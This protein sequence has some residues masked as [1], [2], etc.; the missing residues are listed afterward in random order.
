MKSKKK[1]SIVLFL[2]WVAGA[3][4]FLFFHMRNANQI[5]PEEA[6][7][8]MEYQKTDFSDN[9]QKNCGN[10][11]LIDAVVE[12]GADFDVENC[13]MQ[14]ASC[15]QIDSEMVKELF[16]DVMDSTDVTSYNQIDLFGNEKKGFV[17]GTDHETLMLAEN[18][19]NYGKYPE[20]NYINSAF[21]NP[22]TRYEIGNTELYSQT[23]ELLFGDKSEV[24]ECVKTYLEKM[25]IN[26]EDAVW[27]CYSLDYLTMQ[28]QAQKQTDLKKDEINEGWDEADEVYDFFISEQTEGL[29][30]YLYDDLMKGDWKV[31]GQAP[32]SLIYGKDGIIGIKISGW[33]CGMKNQQK[34][35][36]FVSLDEIANTITTHFADVTNVQKITITKMK[37]YMYP[38]L[39]NENTCKVIPIWEC[40]FENENLESGTI[41]I[42]AQTGEEFF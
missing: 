21:H 5:K 14:E 19:L 4:L 1:L 25:G 41:R 17:Y 11:V 32:V 28:E 18:Y 26:R 36:K 29:P 8:I 23:K 10:K 34:P 16:S 31:E 27:T 24:T 7:D 40:E 37:L 20:I 30:V 39:E 9:Y 6:V 33:I 3:I 38:V 35:L 42:N 15:F 22:S 2:L 12:T 13:Y